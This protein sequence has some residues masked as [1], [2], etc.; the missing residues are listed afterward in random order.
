MSAEVRR[1]GLRAGSSPFMC[2]FGDDRVILYTG[3]DDVQ[4]MLLTL[5]TNRIRMDDLSSI[6]DKSENVK[7]DD[8]DKNNPTDEHMIQSPATCVNQNPND[9]LARPSGNGNRSFFDRCG[10][11]TKNDKSIARLDDVLPELQLV[12]Y[13]TPKVANISGGGFSL[14]NPTTHNSGPNYMKNNI[15]LGAA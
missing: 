4:V 14:A 5:E 7:L 2:V 10:K 8:L 12:Y 3:V 15:R 11:N 9:T 13:Q 1:A 6:S